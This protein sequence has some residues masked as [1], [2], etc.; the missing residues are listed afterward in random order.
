MKDIV[1]TGKMIKAEILIALG[2]LVFAECLNLFAI[3][4][5]SRPVVELVS[6]IGYVVITAVLAYLILAVIRLVVKF[7]LWIVNRIKK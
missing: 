2:C 7:V 4:K 6:M 1:I 5:Y 3:I